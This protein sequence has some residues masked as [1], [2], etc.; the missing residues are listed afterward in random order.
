MKSEAKT[1]PTYLAELDPE[2]RSVLRKLRAMIRRVAP[3]AK[4]GMD[5]G[6]PSYILE[7][8]MLCAFAAQKN[9]LAFYLC[10][11][12]LVSR[13]RSELGTSDCGK[14]CIRYRK[15]EAMRIP[16]LE[17]MLKL[18]FAARGGGAKKRA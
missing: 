10:D 5:Y 17:E 4:E 8:E 14:S 3:R 11:M 12:E 2:K 13:F 6:M 7:G 9:F 15:P 16:V 18:A 1:V